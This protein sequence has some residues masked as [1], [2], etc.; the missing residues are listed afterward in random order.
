M[1]LAEMDGVDGNTSGEHGC[2]DVWCKWLMLLSLLLP[3]L[4]M[5]AFSLQSFDQQGYPRSE[6]QIQVKEL[7][8]CSLVSLTWLLHLAQLL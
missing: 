7:G 4:P 3:E 6:R 1:C 5:T 2:L 8:D